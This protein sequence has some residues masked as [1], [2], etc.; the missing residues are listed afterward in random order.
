MFDAEKFLPKTMLVLGRYRFW[1]LN[2]MYPNWLFVVS[3]VRPHTTR[4]KIPERFLPQYLQRTVRD[5]IRRHA[6]LTCDCKNPQTLN[7]VLKVKLLI[8]R[9]N[10]SFH[11][12][13]YPESIFFPIAQSTKWVRLFS[14]SGIHE[15]TQ[16]YHTR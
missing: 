3:S 7:L 5:T 6:T 4:Q 1:S 15:Y 13:N 2:T 10:Y 9:Y 16:T 8:C 12:F 14:L 11:F